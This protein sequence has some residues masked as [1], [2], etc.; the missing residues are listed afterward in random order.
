MQHSAPSRLYWTCQIL[1]WGGYAVSRAWAAIIFLHLPWL[2]TIAAALALHGA[3]LGATHAMR[4]YIARRGWRTLRPRALAWRIILAGLV[5]GVPLGVATYFTPI[6]ALQDPRVVDLSLDLHAGPGVILVLNAVNWAFLFWTWL[7]LY[8][9]VLAVRQYRSA[10]LRQS[11]LARAL[12]LAE[13]RLLKSQLN[14]HFLFNALNTVRSLIADDPARAQDAVTRLANTLRYTLSSAQEELVTLA[15]ELEIVQDYLDLESLR[16]EDRLSIDCEVTDEARSATI[17]VM[18][19]QTIVENAIKHGIAE[20]PAGGVLRIRGELRDRDLV[21]EVENPRP[22]APRHRGSEGGAG[23]ENSEGSEGIGLR[24]A[25]ERLRLLF[26]DR[27]SLEVD[28]SR[29]A[30]AIAK[31]RIP[32]K[33]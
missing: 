25:A 6:A 10:E 5:L 20:L 21:L 24:N 31:V 14:P 19:L 2:S 15:Q 29:P 3:A 28:L 16:L 7:T 27:A 26:G 18:L 13:L 17:P 12:H 32:T 11:E 4:E 22:S 30:I 23:N 9:I 1:G 33:V 8:F